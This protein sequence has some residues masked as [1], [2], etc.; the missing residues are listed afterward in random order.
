MGT[1]GLA[2]AQG[3]QGIPGPT[4]PAGAN[5]GIGPPG[6]SN[7][8]Y[9]S[10]WVWTTKVTDANTS[11]QVGLNASTWAA[12]TFVNVNEAK[13]DNADVSFYLNSIAVGDLLYVQQKTDSTRWGRYSVTG[14]TDMGNWRRFNVTFLEGAGIVPNGNADTA[15]T[16]VKET[17]A[18]LALTGL[19][20]LIAGSKVVAVPQVTANSRI[21]LTIQALGTVATPQAVGVTARVPGTSFTITSANGADTSSIAWQIVEP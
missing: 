11:G 17:A 5:G 3:P 4:G 12:A 2:G 1:T 19:V 6:A 18:A 9:T 8:L 20:A 10:T 21:L 16:I 14:A 7:A 15:F 13:K